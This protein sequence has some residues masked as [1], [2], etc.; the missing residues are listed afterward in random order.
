MK[1]QE[2]VKKNQVILF[3]KSFSFKKYKKIYLNT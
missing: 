1:K 3:I 2:M